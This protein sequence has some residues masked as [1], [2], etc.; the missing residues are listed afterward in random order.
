MD[1][2]IFRRAVT[3]EEG[4]DGGPVYSEGERTVRIPVEE[5]ACRRGRSW[6][7]EVGAGVGWNAN[8]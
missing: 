4:F 6:G 3:T 5:L 8:R 7:R 2:L 1:E